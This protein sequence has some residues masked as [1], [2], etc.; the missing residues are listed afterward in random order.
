MNEEKETRNLNEERP[1][2]AGSEPRA[3]GEVREP[4]EVTV[5]AGIEQTE[6]S[7]GKPE[8]A[9]PADSQELAEQELNPAEPDVPALENTASCEEPVTVSP[10]VPSSPKKESLFRRMAGKSWYV[11]RGPEILVAVSAAAAVLLVS[12]V[13]SASAQSSLKAQN[14]AL[15][16]QIQDLEGQV[17][18]A[19]YRYQAKLEQVR[20]LKSEVDELKHGKSRRLEEVQ[21]AHKDGDWEKTISL[22][23]DLHETYPGS[24]EDTEGQKL[25]SD[26]QNKI[27][28]AEE[29][30]KR[31]KEE[32]ARKKAE[33]EARGY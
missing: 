2:E 20:E 30:E 26:A 18:D 22:A 8:P 13:S 4:E 9:E 27:K 3:G 15:S 1:E 29:A 31:K 33:E 16:L 28:E 6:D 21:A 19:E 24:A 25:K 23:D 14:E 17:S 5:Q 10:A 7:D 32:A 12:T 11:K